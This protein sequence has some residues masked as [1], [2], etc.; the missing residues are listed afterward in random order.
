MVILPLT[1]HLF[2]KLA[3]RIKAIRKLRVLKT[4][5]LPPMIWKPVLQTKYHFGY[6]AFCI[7]NIMG[8][9]RAFFRLVPKKRINQSHVLPK[10]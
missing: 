5:T 6:S 1:K 9:F 10:L 3:G 4:P 2:L 8:G 7:E